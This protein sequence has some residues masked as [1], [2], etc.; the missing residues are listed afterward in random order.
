MITKQKI[1]IFIPTYNDFHHLPQ[2]VEDIKKILPDS[3][4]LIVDDG[5]EQLFSKDQIKSPFK[6]FRVPNNLGISFCMNIACDY[7][8]KHKF[9]ILVRLDADNQHPIEKIPTL[10]NEINQQNDLVAGSRENHAESLSVANFFRL[11]LKR[12]YSLFTSF[13]SRQQMPSD[14]NTGFMAFNRTAINIL[15][16]YQL[17][18]YPEPQIFLIAS[19]EKLKVKEIFVTQSERIHGKSSIN[20]IQAIKMFYQFHIF[21]LVILLRGMKNVKCDSINY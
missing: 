17:D 10:I 11:C 15:N 1:L 14:V 8:L 20:L 3:T 21:I 12:Y 6:Y 2:I 16:Q 13:L 18:R 4:V 19:K 5:S 7:A 9:D